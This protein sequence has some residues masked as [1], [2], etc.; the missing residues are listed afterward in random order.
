M[1]VKNGMPYLRE[2]LASLETQTYKGAQ[3][4]VW[5]N[6]STDGTREELSKWIPGRIQGRVVFNRPMTLAQ[7]LAAMTEESKSDYCAR[8]DADDIPHPERL[9]KQAAF[10][11]SH[12]DVAVVG[13]QMREIDSEGNARPARKPYPVTHDDIVNTLIFE[14]P[15]GHPSVLL[16]RDAVLKAGNY[17]PV[18]PV[19]IEDYDLWLRIAVNDKMANLDEELTTYRVHSRSTTV[20]SQATN[21][22][23]S[24]VNKVISDAGPSLY[25]CSPEKIHALREHKLNNS[26]PVIRKIASSLAQRAGQSVEQRLHQ[27]SLLDS[28]Q[29]LIAPDDFRATLEIASRR[30]DPIMLEHEWNHM[31]NFDSRQRLLHWRFNLLI[32]YR[33]KRQQRKF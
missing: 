7:S 12:P 26:W 18:G 1:P 23:V 13:T 28:V 27:K 21:T 3:I 30:P 8:I 14:N 31:P 11:D 19:N 32:A 22:L 4:I 2:T 16:R 17:R 25:K 24:A 6:G 9:H 20:E 10:L 5:D 33:R 15:I 29:M